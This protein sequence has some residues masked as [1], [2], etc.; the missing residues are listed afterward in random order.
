[1][2]PRLASP[3]LER[4][5]QRATPLFF[6]SPVPPSFSGSRA[7]PGASPPPFHRPAALITRHRGILSWK[8]ETSAPRKFPLPRFF[9]PLF[10][11]SLPRLSINLFDSF[12]RSFSF[13]QP[14]PIPR[15]LFSERYSALYDVSPPPRARNPFSPSSRPSVRSAYSVLCNRIGDRYRSW[16]RSFDSVPRLLAARCSVR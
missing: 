13:H 4:S 7:D 2:S 12:S 16:S 11:P 5:H 8:R 9:F 3:R 14:S 6:P 10:R 1:M 15:H